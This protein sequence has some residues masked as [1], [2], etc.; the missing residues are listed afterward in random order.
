MHFLNL[1][2]NCNE[3]V[4]IEQ[5]SPTLAIHFNA[6]R[7]TCPQIVCFHWLRA[8]ALHQFEKDNFLTCMFSHV[9]YLSRLDLI[10]CFFDRH[11]EYQLFVS[12]YRGYWTVQTWTEWTG[13]KNTSDFM[14]WTLFKYNWY[15]WTPILY[16]ILYS[17]NYFILIY[18]YV[19]V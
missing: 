11:Y 18:K 4:S 14:N 8:A 15:F 16:L 7:Y 6:L 1:P 17:C 2:N 5:L 12:N 3:V 19:V 13:S 10:V 9:F